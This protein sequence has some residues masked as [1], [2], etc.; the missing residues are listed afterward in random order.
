MVAGDWAE[1]HEAREGVALRWRDTVAVWSWVGCTVRV[2]AVA[3]LAKCSRP[4]V[5]AVARCRTVR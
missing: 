5:V 2:C 4:R 3:K 1:G